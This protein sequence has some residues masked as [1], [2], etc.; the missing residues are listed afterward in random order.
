MISGRP[1]VSFRNKAWK[2]L[3]SRDIHSVEIV[4]GADLFYFGKEGAIVDILEK[5]FSVK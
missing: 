2:T 3:R 5:H 1:F 4:G